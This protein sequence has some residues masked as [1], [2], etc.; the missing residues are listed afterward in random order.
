MGQVRSNEFLKIVSQEM[1]LTF[2]IFNS[3]QKVSYSFAAVSVS[4]QNQNA[5]GTVKLLKQIHQ[6]R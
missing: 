1:I 2:C 6:L 5:S 3:I 4:L